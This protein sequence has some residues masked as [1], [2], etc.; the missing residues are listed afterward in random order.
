MEFETL[1]FELRDGV[2]R[3][4]LNRPDA[5]NSLN[6]RMA[7]ELHEVAIRCDVDPEVRAVL[8]TGTGAMFCAGGDLTAGKGVQEKGS[9]PFNA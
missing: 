2:G 3:I 7:R 4:T 8:M 5:A 1:R 9:D 6:L